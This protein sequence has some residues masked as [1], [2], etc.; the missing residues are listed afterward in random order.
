MFTRLK[1]RFKERLLNRF[2]PP[3]DFGLHIK[4]RRDAWIR[5][6]LAQLPEG[7]RI[8]DAGAGEC[9]YKDFCNHLDYISQDFGQYDGKGDSVGMQ[10][11]AWDNSKLDIVCDICEI[12]EPEASFD[13]ILCSEVLEHLP[14]PL[15]A[16]AEFSRLLKS[17]GKLL[18]TAPFCSRTHFAPYHF[19]TGFS[20]YFYEHHLPEFGFVIEECTADG[21]YF[22]H[23]ASD[24][25]YLPIA[26]KDYAKDASPQNGSESFV[27]HLARRVILHRLRQFSEADSGSSALMCRGYHVR[28][29]RECA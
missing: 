9:P 29:R 3:T 17:G 23:M 2:G 6:Q 20:R 27:Y 15:N 16:I 7:L 11:G 28:A 21:G 22:E 8:L 25:H 5:D 1:N 13:A 18:I 26:E 14:R 19:C 24:M 12:P 4:E 10:T